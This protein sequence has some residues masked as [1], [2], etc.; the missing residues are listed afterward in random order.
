MPGPSQF[1][2][3]VITL[4]ENICKSIF[5]HINTV[6]PGDLINSYLIFFQSIPDFY[7][8]SFGHLF[9][10][11]QGHL[12][13]S[14]I[15]SY[16]CFSLFHFLYYGS[17]LLFSFT[18]FPTLVWNQENYTLTN[19]VKAKIEQDKVKQGRKTLGNCNRG[20]KLNLPPLKQRG[21]GILSTGASQWKLL[22]DIKGRVMN[23]M[24]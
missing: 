14:I 6:A 22:D 19:C 16:L 3:R 5:P 11:F 23:G 17:C 18:L 24:C 1:I 21:E 4:Q 8:F 13:G 9:Q 2:D 7:F 10:T 15:S 20:E 12:A